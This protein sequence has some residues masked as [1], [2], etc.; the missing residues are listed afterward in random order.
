MKTRRIE[1][2]K[3]ISKDQT[4]NLI[5]FGCSRKYGGTVFTEVD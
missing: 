1:V 4:A 5:N 3:P 2:I